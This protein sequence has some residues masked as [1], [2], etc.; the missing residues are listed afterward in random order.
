MFNRKR[1]LTF[2]FGLFFFIIFPIGAQ[3]DN[4]FISWDVSAKIGT[5]WIEEEGSSWY[6]HSGLTF[7]IGQ[8]LLSGVDLAHVSI[9]LPWLD[10][11]FFGFKGCFGVDMPNGGFSFT[12]GFINQS[13]LRAG[14][15][16]FYVSNEGGE[17]FF[18]SLKIPIHFNTF[19]IIP[20]ILYSKASWENGDMYWFYGKLRLPSLLAYGFTV[21]HNHTGC[22]K[23]GPGF[24]GLHIALN[25]FNNRNDP[26]FDSHLNAGFFFYQLSFETTKISFLT[27]VGWA[28]TNALFEGALTSLNQPFFLFPYIFYNVNASFTAQA[29]FALL[30]F[31]YTPGVF[32]YSINL[33]SFHIFHDLIQ[34]DIHYQM[35]NLF[36]GKEVFDT[37]YFNTKGL[38]AAFLVFETIFPALSIGRNRQFFLGLEKIFALPWGH[39][40]L[41]AFFNN[42]SPNGSVSSGIDIQ[43]LLRTVLLSGLSVRGSFSI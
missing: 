38:G 19:N 37:L 25:I 21:N 7:D 15:D 13:L 26:L 2:W 18:L 3:D 1:A 17:G 5:L 30:Y 22:I 41:L 8:N 23:H 24:H 35:K 39:E 4:R 40:K 42:S 33:G 27:T 29:G 14:T 36:G 32:Q 6:W 43:S 12:S 16:N 20:S 31:V 11:A 10:S 28:Y 34:A 9:S